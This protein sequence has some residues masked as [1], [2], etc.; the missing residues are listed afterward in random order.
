MKEFLIPKQMQAAVYRGKNDVRIETVPV[1]SIRADEILVKVALCGVC[2]TDIKK[3]KAGTLEPPRIF[4]HET[5][6][7][8]VKIGAK[9][10]GFSLGDRVGLHHHVPCLDCRFCRHHAYAQCAQYKRTG[11]TAG[12]EPAGGGFAEYVKVMGFCLPGVVK[13]P[14]RADFVQGA[15]LEPVNTVLKGIRTLR[16]LRGD[17]VWV[18]GQ[19]PIGLLFTRILSRSGMSVWATDLMPERRIAAKKAGAAWTGTPEETRC[20]AGNQP[21]GKRRMDKELDA[22]VVTVPVDAAVGEALHLVRPGGVVL[23]FGHTQSGGNVAVD[24]GGCCVDEKT[25]LGSYSSDF[26]LQTAAARFCFSEKRFL[27]GLVNETLPLSQAA[28]AI[29]HAASPSAGRLKVA[30]RCG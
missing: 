8:I 18:I 28:L 6:G 9:V 17:N 11:I 1:P 29:D 25:L 19:G 12:F 22:V 7:T 10:S 27:S 26:R 15:M 20:F 5:A 24:P 14:A 16:L 23:L 21:L 13:I 4:G 30:V 2:P 3:I